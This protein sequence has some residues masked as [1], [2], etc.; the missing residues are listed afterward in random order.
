MFIIFFVGDVPSIP[1]INRRI[2]KSI[3]QVKR[4]MLKYPKIDCHDH[5]FLILQISDLLGESSRGVYPHIE[6]SR[7]PTLQDM[8]IQI[9][10]QFI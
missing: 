5:F 2:F 7:T 6:T 8:V 1:T 3:L 9:P 4:M 10:T